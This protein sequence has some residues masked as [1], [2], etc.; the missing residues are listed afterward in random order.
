MPDI[1]YQKVDNFVLPDEYT[2]ANAYLDLV[3][4]TRCV[5]Q[6]Y[7]LSGTGETEADS[8]WVGNFWYRASH[9]LARARGI[10]TMATAISYKLFGEE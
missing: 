2:A 7:P 5:V 6:G 9:L 4:S 3:L 10:K 1:M 8:L